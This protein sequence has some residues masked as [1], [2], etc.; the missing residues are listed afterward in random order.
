MGYS[1]I[2]SSARTSNA[3]Y[4]YSYT[5]NNLS[6]GTYVYRLKQIDNNGSYK[7]SQSVE[8]EVNSLPVTIGLSQNYPNPFNPSTK[9]SFAL[10]NT[11]Y[12][13]LVVY[14]MLGQQVKTLFD[15]IADG[16]KEYVVTFDA[17]QLASG[18]YFY[19]MQTATQTDVRRMLL[20]K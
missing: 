1:W 9:I 7:Y 13:R 11:E 4:N 8:L 10:A 12:A 3:T 14:N 16:Q 15:G 18:I 19:K 20:V 6:A 17:S 5:D 2:C